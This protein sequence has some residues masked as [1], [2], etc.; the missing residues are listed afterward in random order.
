LLAKLSLKLVHIFKT[1]SQTYF[2][3]FIISL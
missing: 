3:W 2:F 1:G